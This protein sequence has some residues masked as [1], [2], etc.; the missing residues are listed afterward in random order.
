MH[1]YGLPKESLWLLTVLPIACGSMV[2]ICSLSV[3][4]IVPG[5]SDL[6]LHL[7]LAWQQQLLVTEDGPQAGRGRLSHFRHHWIASGREP[8]RVPAQR[9]FG[10]VERHGIALRVLVT[11]FEPF[12]GDTV[13]TS[14][15]AVTRLPERWDEPEID[16]RTAILPVTF[17][18]AP[19]ALAEAIDKH[20]PDAV[21]PA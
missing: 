10:A 9:Y 1:S 8:H 4:S 15:E 6:L 14:G 18:G 13:N 17:A 3:Q 2:L 16:L 7:Q 5:L 11:G 19:V 20:Q 12:G 21:M